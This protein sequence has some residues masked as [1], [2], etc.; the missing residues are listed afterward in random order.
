M[1]LEMNCIWFV[2]QRVGNTWMASTFD[3]NQTAPALALA[4]DN[5]FVRLCWAAA[6]QAEMYGT[7]YAW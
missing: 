7:L 1:L 3:P 6:V 2:L 4:P 5:G